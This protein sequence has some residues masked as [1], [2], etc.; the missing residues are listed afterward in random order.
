MTAITKRDLTRALKSCLAMCGEQAGVIVSA[1]STARLT[2][3]VYARAEFTLGDGSRLNLWLNI[4]LKP[5]PKTPRPLIS[6]EAP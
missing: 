4:D 2:E 3:G 6:E 1:A 5:A